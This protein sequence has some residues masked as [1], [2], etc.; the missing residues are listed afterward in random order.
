MSH[1]AELAE[2][3][4]SAFPSGL[5][6]PILARPQS[7]DRFLQSQQFEGIGHSKRHIEVPRHRVARIVAAPATIRIVQANHRACG[8]WPTRADVQ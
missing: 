8:T 1:H 4:R 3:L 7:A 5:A 6:T 2:R